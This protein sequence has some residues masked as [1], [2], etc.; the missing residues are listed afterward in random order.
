[1]FP[2]LQDYNEQAIGRLKYPKPIS[3]PPSPTSSRGT[4]PVASVHGSD[5]ESDS[6]D[7]EKEVISTSNIFSL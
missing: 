3:E 7:E 4:T 6:V 1:M 2:E 5:D